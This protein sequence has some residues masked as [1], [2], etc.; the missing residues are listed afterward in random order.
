MPDFTLGEKMVRVFNPMPSANLQDLMKLAK[1]PDWRHR[2]N[3]R[4]AFDIM[5]KWSAGIEEQSRELPAQGSMMLP[6]STANALLKSGRQLRE[7]GLVILP[8]GED[9]CFAAE[10]GLTKALE[11]FTKIGPHAILKLKRRLGISS[12]ADEDLAR[13]RFAGYYVAV[14]KMKLVEKELKKVTD[15]CEKIELEREEAAEKAKSKGAAAA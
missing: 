14:E 8:E 10:K 9:P 2:R 13:T 11:F 3:K 6:L 4:D 5:V 15:K 12:K 1:H 7:Q